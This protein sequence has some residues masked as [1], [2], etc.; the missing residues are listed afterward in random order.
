MNTFFIIVLIVFFFFNLAKEGK[1]KSLTLETHQFAAYFSQR[2]AHSQ[3]PTCKL[4]ILHL[5]H[6][7]V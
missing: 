4:Q 3:H 6:F 1:A 5:C 2:N 7:G